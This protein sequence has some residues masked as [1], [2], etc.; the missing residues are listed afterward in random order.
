MIEVR[1][2][3]VD[4]G[5][6]VAVEN[7]SFTAKASEVYG[8]IGPNGAGK[9]T[10]IKAIA[11]LLEPTYGEILVNGVS[12][13]HEPEKVRGMLGYMPDF[14]PVYDDLRVDEFVEL[15]AAAYGL[16]T[17]KRRSEVDRCLEITDLGDKR[18]ALCKTLSRGMK[19]RALL[20]KT[21]VHDPPV[22]LLD[23]PAANLDPKARIKL[24][25]L[26]KELAANGKA[27]LVSSHVLS[28]LQDL[29]DSIGIMRQGNM[30][31]SGNLD[32]VADKA[33]SS[34]TIRVDLV[35]PFPA[36][37][38]LIQEHPLAQLASEVEDGTTQLEIAFDG[39]EEEVAA[40]LKA[41]VVS[42]APVKS[43]HQRKADVEELFLA[44][45][46]GREI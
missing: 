19:Q 12:A 3:K 24:R 15:F 2:L 41:F 33:R 30:V 39:G 27:I 23:E 5:D 35:R 37:H 42:G 25:N 10:T 45:E 14:P 6:T 20:A 31:I 17:E 29:C 36:A 21:L 8:L 4:Y 32:E 22:L 38:A 11:T 40:L 34:R 18:D 16:P 44:V 7:L 1:D 13:L 28:E 43:F 26:L 46:E 9:T